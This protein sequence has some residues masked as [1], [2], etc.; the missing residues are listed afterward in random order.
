MCLHIPS[1]RKNSLRGKTNQSVSI[2]RSWNKPH[3][4]CSRRTTHSLVALDT[5]AGR[6]LH[7]V[8]W[9][10]LQWVPDSDPL[11]SNIHNPPGC[12]R[13]QLCRT[14]C[15][16]RDSHSQPCRNYSPVRRRSQYSLECLCN[17]EGSP[18]RYNECH[19]I[20]QLSW[21]KNLQRYFT[22]RGVGCQ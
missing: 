21:L 5:A 11:Q 15:Q 19:S 2:Q 17:I 7:W 8:W 22:Y 6:P 18:L 10:C 1:F 14:Q 13:H 12:L 3:H 9:W 4:A 16:S 20:V